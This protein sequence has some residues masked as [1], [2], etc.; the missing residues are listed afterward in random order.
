MAFSPAGPPGYAAGMGGP[1]PGHTRVSYRRAPNFLE[2][3]GGSL[4]GSIVGVFLIAG[5]C[6]LLFL[7]EVTTFSLLSLSLCECERFISYS[8]AC[9][10]GPYTRT[11][12][13]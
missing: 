5:A 1:S 6:I 7:N 4:C 11:T 8:R 10:E 2:R 9:R 3:V 12:C 13:W